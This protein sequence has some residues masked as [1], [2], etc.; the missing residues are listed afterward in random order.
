MKLDLHP[1][2]RAISSLSGLLDKVLDTDWMSKQDDVVRF[3]LQ[4]GVIKNFEITYELCWK[5]MQ[6]WIQNNFE[7][8]EAEF[9]RTRKELFR[10]AAKYGLIGNSDA[11]FEYGDARN[12]TSHVYDEDKATEVYELTFRFVE[13]ARRFLSILEHLND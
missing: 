6:R 9:P 7:S 13:D 12:M 10:S 8:A 3:G 5:Y 11:W 2:S 1:L 4:A